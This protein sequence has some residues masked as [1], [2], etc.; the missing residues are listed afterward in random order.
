MEAI[1]EACVVACECMEKQIP[2]KVD[3]C[4]KAGDVYGDCP[5]C[6][7]SYTFQK[8]DE[9]NFCPECGQKLDWS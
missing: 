7:Q 9:F 2:K 1:N 5:I 6:R 8:G 3:S 4:E